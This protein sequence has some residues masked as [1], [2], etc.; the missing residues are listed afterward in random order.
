TSILGTV[1]DAGLGNSDLSWVTNY[2]A[3]YPCG[4][5]R[6][7]FHAGKL[8]LPL[9]TNIVLQQTYLMSIGFASNA[10]PARTS[11]PSPKQILNSRRKD[12][13]REAPAFPE[14]IALHRS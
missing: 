4:V 5:H 3:N 14:R 9:R 6:P 7:D 10:S 1:R 12:R 2:S 11:A 8:R 13:D